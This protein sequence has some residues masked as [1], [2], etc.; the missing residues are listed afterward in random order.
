MSPD[1]LARLWRQE[2][3]TVEM[4]IGHIT[5]NL[6]QLHGALD[7]QRQLLQASLEQQRNLLLTLQDALPT[8]P[9]PP[10]ARPAK[11]RRSQ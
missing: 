10:Q 6:V 1:D 5:Q 3:L 2:H 9:H 7:A 11:R 4:A 8:L